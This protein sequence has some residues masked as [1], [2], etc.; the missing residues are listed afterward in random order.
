MRSLACQEAAASDAVGALAIEHPTKGGI[1][2]MA[3]KGGGKKKG[4]KKR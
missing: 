4:G 1:R 2:G 3:K